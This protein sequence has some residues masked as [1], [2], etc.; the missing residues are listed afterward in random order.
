[1]S[2]D[3]VAALYVFC[4]NY[5]TGQWSKLYKLMSRIV[6]QYRPHLTDNAWKAIQDGEGRAVDEWA[7]ARHYYLILVERHG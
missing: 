7:I 6:R 3:K 2:F 1:M 4:A 5:H